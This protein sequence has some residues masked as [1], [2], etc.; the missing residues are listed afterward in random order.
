ME[1]SLVSQGTRRGP[2]LLAGEELSW[3]RQ[4]HLLVSAASMEQIQSTT[5]FQDGSQREAQ[6]SA[7][8]SLNLGAAEGLELWKGV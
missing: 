2:W 3:S 1:L 6:G 7:G 5:G 8:V 4:K